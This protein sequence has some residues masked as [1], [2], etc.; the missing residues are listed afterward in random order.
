MEWDWKNLLIRS[1]L[2]DKSF[3]L[4]KP[5]V[6]FI[7]DNIEPNFKLSRYFFYRNKKNIGKRFASKLCR[8]SFYFA[9]KQLSEEKDKMHKEILLL[10]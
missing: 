5:Y 2:S 9:N 8:F 4:I 3:L 6:G 7:V 10:S 1:R